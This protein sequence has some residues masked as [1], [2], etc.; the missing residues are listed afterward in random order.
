MPSRLIPALSSLALLAACGSGG[1]DGR[2]RDYASRIE[3]S[4]AA[5]AA[6]YPNVQLPA[7]V[8]CSFDGAALELSCSATYRDNHGGVGTQVKRWRYPSA[9]AF[10][11]EAALLGATRSVAY[12]FSDS[13][14]GPG[15][16]PLLIPDW[17]LQGDNTFAEARLLVNGRVTFVQWDDHERPLRSAATGICTNDNGQHYGY[18]EAMAQV[19]WR[20]NTRTSTPAPDGTIPCIARS[21]LW[22][23]DAGGHIQAIDDGTYRTVRTARICTG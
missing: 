20:W 23:F 9:L 13:G 14:Q 10:V 16:P 1:G 8:D 18:D 5:I 17:P 7:V 4:G 3:A 6:G 19:T 22:R 11:N 21:R 15:G 12:S 2:C